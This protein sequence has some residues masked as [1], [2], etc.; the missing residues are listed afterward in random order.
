MTTITLF[1]ALLIFIVAF[2]IFD[3]LLGYIEPLKPIKIVLAVV[4]AALLSILYATGG[5]L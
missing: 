1:I 3:W 5:K 4:I 2:V